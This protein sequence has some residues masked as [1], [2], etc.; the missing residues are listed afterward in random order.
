[1]KRVLSLILAVL[2]L[3]TLCAACGNQPSGETTEPQPST[4]S[5]E[6]EDQIKKV[7][8]IGNSHSCDAF[9]LLPSVYADQK[10]DQQLV[11]GIM[12]YSGCPMEKHAE[13]SAFDVPVYRYYKNVNNGTWSNTGTTAVKTALED[14]QWDEVILQE[15]TMEVDPSL[16]L[17]NRRI[18]EGVVNK[19]E[20]TPHVIS[21]H[22]PWPC[23]SDE[24][25][26][27]GSEFLVN[28]RANLTARFGFD[29]VNHFT[30][31]T[32]LVKENILPDETYTNAFCT[33]AG[34][35]H[36][37]LTMGRP[38]LELWRDYTHLTDYGRLIAAYSL[39]VQME[40]KQVETVGID[41]VPA[42]LRTE[43]ARKEGDLQVT[44]EMKDVIAA[45]ANYTLD[46]DAR[47]TVPTAAE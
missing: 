45:S 28:Y 35:M 18:V 38:Q 14:E 20:Q 6:E 7:L 16:D 11:V 23:P 47:W 44:D 31:L 40:D 24:S 22:T 46:K 41:A 33:G 10:P 17:D 43:T 3:L 2:L 8:I 34:I 36:A 32:D 21:W 13:Y 5:Q 19:Y 30:F 4:L 42:D 15:F 25:L 26:F 9:W 1:M 37:Y 29:H 39:F 27:E 12:Y